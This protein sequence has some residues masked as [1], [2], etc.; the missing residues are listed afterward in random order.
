M[1][2]LKLPAS[3]VTE[4]PL[5]KQVG[6]HLQDLDGQLFQ[7]RVLAYASSTWISHANAIQVFYSFVLNGN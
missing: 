4:S 6:D 2:L 7:A 1:K 3:S 5:Y